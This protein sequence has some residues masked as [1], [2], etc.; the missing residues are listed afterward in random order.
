MTPAKGYFAKLL[1]SA[2][3][4][5][6]AITLFHLFGA[7][8]LLS[9]GELAT[10]FLVSIGVFF[11]VSIVLAILSWLLSK[12][13]EKIALWI[14]GLLFTF[15]LLSHLGLVRY[16]SQTRILLG[17]DLFG[18][19]FSDILLTVGASGGFDLISFIPVVLIIAT[20]MASPWVFNWLKVESVFDFAFLALGLV[21][22]FLSNPIKANEARSEAVYYAMQNP[23]YYFWNKSYNL[24]ADGS[25]NLEFETEIA[26]YP[27]FH[28]LDL[29]NPL[30]GLLNTSGKLPNIVIIAVEGLGADFVGDG[31]YS[32][33]TPFLDSLIRESLYWP[34]TLSNA[35]RTFGALPSITGSLPYSGA[36]FMAKGQDMPQHQSLFTMLKPLGYSS[37][38][39]YG[40]NAN[41]DGQ[42]IFLEQNQVDYILDE[43]KFPKNMKRMQANTEGFSWGF[44]DQDLFTYSLFKTPAQ[45]PRLSFYMTLATHEP[46]FVPEGPYMA[47]AEKLANSKRTDQN[48]FKEFTNVFACI[49][50]T[51]VA[52]RNFLE[53]CKL[54]PD[55][56]NT[57]FI[58]T[59][60]HRLIPI[61]AEQRIS[62]FHVPLIIYSPMIKTPMISKQLAAHSQITP[63]IIALLSQT[64][65]QPLPSDNSFISVPL[66]IEKE[67]GSEL[68][69]PLMRNK[70]EME[71]YVFGEYLLNGSDLYKLS[72]GMETTRLD[73]NELLSIMKSKLALF[74]L[75]SDLA[76]NENRLIPDSIGIESSVRRVYSSEELALLEKL[77]LRYSDS[78]DSI[79]FAARA[80]AFDG[81]FVDSRLVANFGLAKSPNYHDLR[82]LIARTYA[83]SG[84]Y[85]SAYLYL[86]ETLRRAERY[87]DAF[88]AYADAS[89]WNNDPVKTK[90][91]IELGLVHY[92]TSTELKV[93]QA[94]ELLNSGSLEEGKKILRSVLAEYPNQEIALTLKK[95]FLE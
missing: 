9:F 58:I 32:G 18:Y 43:S 92:P 44:G 31:M 11:R 41:F 75:K 93:R 61:P 4:V 57:I 24:I 37:Q 72:D 29:T 82:I 35:G 74:K 8:E 77:N 95:R 47:F 83:W 14:S 26:K 22:W 28:S 88:I 12:I 87:E 16:V 91:M 52:L 70:N 62:R 40:G 67:F 59:G 79:Y 63:S 85:D 17:A 84:S 53:S 86:D 69:L 46:F 65:N 76:L 7:F 50:Y 30:G 39:F 49:N 33:A 80:L 36:G 68:D 81:L 42:D 51:D 2:F 25:K 20:I 64:Y 94:R 55:F 5:Y 54:R 21:S 60:D 13:N 90:E 23:S 89:F 15:F 38:Y 48:V 56:D 66:A 3:I 34:N 45:T 73:D 10:S 27:F 19:S 6:L 1:L 71:D 78:P